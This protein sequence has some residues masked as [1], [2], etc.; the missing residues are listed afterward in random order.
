M[1]LVLGQTLVATYFMVSVLP[2]HASTAIE[3]GLVVLFALS[4]A[5]ISIGAWLALFG[6]ILR[7]LGGDRQRRCRGVPERPTADSSARTALLMPIYHEPVDAC[8]AGIAAVFQSLEGTGE[9]DRFDVFV[10]SDSR[11]P[12]ILEAEHAAWKY[13]VQRLVASGRFFYRRRRVNLRHKSG[14]IADFLRRWG[15]SYDYFVVLDADSLMNA[16]TLLRMVAVMDANPRAGIIQ[17]PPELVAARS[18]FARLQQFAN[19]LYGP[20]FSTGLAALQLG[21]GAYWGHN[22]I[23]RTEAFMRHCALPSLRGFGLFR[24]PIMSHDFVEATYMRRGGYEVWL[25][26]DLGGSYEQS[27]PSIVDELTRD[28]RWARGNLQH[29][30]IMLSER[31]LGIPQRLIFLNGIVAYAAA[32]LWLGFLILSGL[33]VAQ[34]TLFPIDYFP[35]GHQ[36]FPV[37]PEWHPEWAARLIGSTA[38]VLFLPKFLA[39]VDALFR[40]QR[41]RGFGGGLRLAAGTLIETVVSILLAPVR[42]LAHSRFMAEALLNL[43]LTWAGQNRGDAIG[44]GTA[45]RMHGVGLLL[46]LGWAVFAWWLRP[47]YFY[48]SLPISLPLMLAPIV[49][50]V[51]SRV[52]RRG[53]ALLQTPAETHPPEV[54]RTWARYLQEDKKRGP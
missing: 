20:L 52:A 41:R 36:L 34:F 40:G 29:F 5:W 14:N 32:P 37:W 46:G 42:M 22:A 49:A 8:F 11:D 35:D 30:P 27:P 10:L 31:G 1:L 13:W 9:L 38:V 25:E 6:F 3:L 28:R 45:L 23:I 47:L 4:F 18:R 24:G 44:W 21:D 39:F 19:A 54:V 50:V 33:E 17:S 7:L 51:T 2:Y 48:W 12:D 43:K 26:T 53:G 15:H 16:D